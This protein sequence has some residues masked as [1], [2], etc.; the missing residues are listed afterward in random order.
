MDK[1]TKKWFDPNL[2]YPNFFNPLVANLKAMKQDNVSYK[3]A[4]EKWG[5]FVEAGNKGI[6]SEPDDKTMILGITV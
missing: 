4:N 5:K 2:P 3:E 6:E 1:K